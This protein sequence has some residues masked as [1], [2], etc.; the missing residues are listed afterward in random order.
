[1]EDEDMMEEMVGVETGKDGRVDKGHHFLP[2]ERR[3]RGL[4]R[5]LDRRMHHLR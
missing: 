3:R 1:M 5:R 4:L 2:S